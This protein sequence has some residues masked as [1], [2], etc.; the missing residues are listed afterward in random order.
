MAQTWRMEIATGKGAAIQTA[1]AHATG[2]VMVI[3]DADLEYDPEDLPSLLRPIVEGRAD[4]V[5]GSR[6]LAG[7]HRVLYFWH[8]VGNGLLTLLSDM[9]TDLNLKYDLGPGVSLTSIT[10]YVHRDVLV[11]R[12]ATALTGSVTGGSIGLSESLYTLDAPLNDATTSNVW[13]QEL[14]LA[15]GSGRLKW[16]VGG[17]YG[18]SKRHYA[19]SLLVQRFDTAAAAEL[20]AKGSPTP[21][22]W[23]KG[24]LGAR[25]NELFFSDLHNDLKQA[26]AFGEATLTVTDRLN[27]TAGLRYYHF[28][29]DRSLVFDGIFAV[30]TNATGTTNANGVAPRF[31]VDSNVNND[32]YEEKLCN[33]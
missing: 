22:G 30:P 26:A 27:L 28:T 10:S 20:T 17:F 2:D 29:E 25:V 1:I 31:I 4:A 11:V 14:R 5:F 18:R 32:K 23:T 6:F 8:R 3:Q 33:E 15:G 9:L 7:P 21:P 16:L 13:T 19:Q 24:T 12:D